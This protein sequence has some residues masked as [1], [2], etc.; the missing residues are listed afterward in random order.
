MHVKYIN[1]SHPL[2]A[3]VNRSPLSWRRLQG[4]CS[5]VDSKIWW[6]LGKGFVEFWYDPWLCHTP[7][8]DVVP[9]R[10]PPHI[11]LAEFYGENGWNVECLKAW[12][13]MDI[14]VEIQGI[15]LY[16]DQEDCMVW[17][18]SPSGDFMVKSA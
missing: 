12:L 5:L 10:D 1:G 7:L 17:L 8:A 15:Q 9:I 18:D 16:Q 14:V 4:I 2:I 13:P 3:Q 6:C 11:L